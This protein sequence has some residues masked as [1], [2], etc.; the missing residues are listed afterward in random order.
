M[1]K[2]LH[3][4]RRGPGFDLWSG[5]KSFPCSSVSKK[6]CLQGFDS[7]VR[8]IPWRRRWQPTPAFWPGESYM[9]QLKKKDPVCPKRPGQ[10]NQYINILKKERKKR[11]AVGAALQRGGNREGVARRDWR[12]FSAAGG[13]GSVRRHLCLSQ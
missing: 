1:A 4:Q 11:V 5:N 3:S 7:W 2:T 12:Q 13:P 8:K 6:I 9:T 10:P